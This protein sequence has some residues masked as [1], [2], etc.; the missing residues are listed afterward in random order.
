MLTSD[1]FNSQKWGTWRWQSWQDDDDGEDNVS[2]KGEMYHQRAPDGQPI[3]IQMVLLVTGPVMLLV[4]IILLSQVTRIQMQMV[5]VSCYESPSY[6]FPLWFEHQCGF[7]LTH[8]AA[9]FYDWLALWC[10]HHHQ[11]SQ[12]QTPETNY[13][14]DCVYHCITNILLLLRRVDGSVPTSQLKHQTRN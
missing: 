1:L 4:H 13:N 3:I 5:L 2:S 7:D 8:V 12:H 9:A 11:T 10:Q 6:I 14:A